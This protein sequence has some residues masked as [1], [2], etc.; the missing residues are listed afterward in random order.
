MGD[1]RRTMASA[2]APE[3]VGMLK[4]AMM[5]FQGLRSAASRPSAVSTRSHVGE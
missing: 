4:S 3:N 5:R 2:S 1:I